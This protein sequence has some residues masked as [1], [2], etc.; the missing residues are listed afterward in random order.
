[1]RLSLSFVTLLTLAVVALAGG[2]AAVEASSP[3]QHPIT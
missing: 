1:M 2:V 3:P